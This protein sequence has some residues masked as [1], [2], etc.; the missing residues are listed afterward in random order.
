MSHPGGIASAA[1]NADGHVSTLAL[2]MHRAL[3]WLQS[4]RPYLM[5]IGF[6]LFL[7]TRVF[8]AI[9]AHWGPFA[10]HVEEVLAS[11]PAV[12]WFEVHAE[13]YMGA[14]GPPHRYLTAIRNTYPLSLHGV[15]LSIMSS[16]TRQNA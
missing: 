14:G 5:F 1:G 3:L 10:R 11:H 6:A 8:V 13:N 7:G 4:P 2:T 15:G 9:A 16:V 12:P